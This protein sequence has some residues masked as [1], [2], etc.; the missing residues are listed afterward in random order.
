MRV[1]VLVVSSSYTAEVTHIV[2]FFTRLR[3]HQIEINGAG[4]VCNE[5]DVFGHIKQFPHL[6]ADT[7]LE[8]TLCFSIATYIDLP[9]TLCMCNE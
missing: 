1:W 9:P 6:V 3:I 5:A 8:C 2:I 4:K 7:V